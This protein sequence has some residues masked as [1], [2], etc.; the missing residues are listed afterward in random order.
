MKSILR[1]LRGWLWRIEA[2][3]SGPRAVRREEIALLF[4]RDG[5]S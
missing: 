4:L 3:Y 5:G 2:V 1:F